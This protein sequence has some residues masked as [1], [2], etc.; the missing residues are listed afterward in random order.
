MKVEE[1]L[2]SAGAAAVAAGA[3]GQEFVD[4]G[5]YECEYLVN[6]EFHM[7]V[8]DYVTVHKFHVLLTTV[9]GCNNIM[10]NPVSVRFL[11][12]SSRVHNIGGWF[13]ISLHV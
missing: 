6:I 12:T 1:Q 13:V 11:S 2:T 7:G 5:H 8:C 9:C 4:S 3:E 10:L